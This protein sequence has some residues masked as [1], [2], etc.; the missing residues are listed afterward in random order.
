MILSNSRKCPI[1]GCRAAIPHARLMCK[2]HWFMVP[3]PL[4]E[5]VKKTFGALRT[6]GLDGIAAYRANRDEAIRVVNI[7]VVEDDG[8]ITVHPN[9]KGLPS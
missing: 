6:D 5:A 1:K 3:K 9:V 2:L 7:S 4:R 8:F